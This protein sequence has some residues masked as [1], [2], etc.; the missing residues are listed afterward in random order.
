MDAKQR[1]AGEV[2]ELVKGLKE[3]GVVRAKVDGIEIEFGQTAI[4][5]PVVVDQP[6]EHLTPE[7]YE[8]KAKAIRKK[9]DEEVYAAS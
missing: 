2:L 8:E 9:L 6:P 1:T 3:L 5:Y 7:E 4:G